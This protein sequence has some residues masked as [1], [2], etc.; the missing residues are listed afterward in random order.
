MCLCMCVC[1]VSCIKFHST[2]KIVGISTYS[3][4]EHSIPQT[5]EVAC[6]KQVLPQVLAR[7]KTPM[8]IHIPTWMP[9]HLHTN[10]DVECLV[11][12][13]RITEVAHDIQQ[14]VSCYVSTELGLVNS[15][16][17]WH[18]IYIHNIFLY[19]HLCM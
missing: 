6:T 11:L 7:G 14:Q 3:R 15:Y 13:L 17:T 1:I 19:I 2:Q 12:G 18:S 9:T 16:D 4:A 10:S 8:Y 5:R